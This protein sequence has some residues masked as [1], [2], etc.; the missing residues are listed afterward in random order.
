MSNI[1]NMMTGSKEISDMFAATDDK[2]RTILVLKTF[3][4]SGT[5]CS[6]VFNDGVP[7]LKCFD[8]GKNTIP[9]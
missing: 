1:K 9:T 5:F 3:T 2:Y 6:E 4:A 7:V 8:M